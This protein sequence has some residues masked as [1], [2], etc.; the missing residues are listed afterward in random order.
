MKKVYSLIRHLLGKTDSHYTTITRATINLCQC[1]KTCKLFITVYRMNDVQ[2]N[3][4]FFVKFTLLPHFP[5]SLLQDADCNYEEMKQ[6]HSVG[7]CYGH[8]Q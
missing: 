7:H 6:S 2:Q 5:S 1:P 3:I 4:C 8:V